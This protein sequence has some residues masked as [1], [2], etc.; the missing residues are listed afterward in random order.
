MFSIPS[1]FSFFL[2]NHIA[3]EPFSYVICRFSNQCSTA[4]KSKSFWFGNCTIINGLTFDFCRIKAALKSCCLANALSKRKSTWSDTL[5][6]CGK[7]SLMTINF[8]IRPDAITTASSTS[9]TVAPIISFGVADARMILS[10]LKYCKISLAFTLSFWWLSSTMILNC[11]PL[12]K[13]VSICSKKFFR[14]P[15]FKALLP[16]LVSFSQLTKQQS[17]STKPLVI[18]SARSFV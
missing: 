12:S 9:M 3:K 14:S 8:L 13:A 18:T 11:N 16:D 6:F 4:S 5:I 1:R 10:V 2:L 7:S 15:S 17:F